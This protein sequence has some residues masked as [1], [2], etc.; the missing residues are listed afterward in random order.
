MK[1]L[2]KD[3]DILIKQYCD[4]GI[5]QSLDWHKYNNY[6]IVHHS[7]SIE[8]SSL[9]EEETGL[10]LEE[11]ITAKG[12]PLVHH[13]MQKD[14]YKALLFILDAAE[15][16]VKIDIEFLSKIASIVMSNTGGIINSV[17][18]SFDSSKGELR[19][20]NNYAGET[21]FP[22]FKKVSDLLKLFSDE[23][24]DKM[25][26]FPTSTSTSIST[27]TSTSTSTE[28]LL[29][30]FD[31]HFNLVSIHPFA[32]GN[33][34]VS[35]LL[36]NYIQHRFNQPLTIVF[37]E[38]KADYYKALVETRKHED[39]NIFRKFML[40]QYKKYLSLEIDKV[41]NSQ[42]KVDDILYK[43]G[44]DKNKGQGTSMFFC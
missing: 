19:L 25:N 41:L 5:E 23:L 18:G 24:N 34:R 39:K 13:H 22:D 10:L 9:T 36:M 15:K 17:S 42:K 35:R 8:G 38:D 37:K 3:I 32:D 33:G 30:S 20:V 27:S 11:D 44:K 14:H 12:K 40:E 7:T 31:A 16:K 6:S 43:N 2:L 21:R 29:T 26:Q 4:L 1:E 28:I